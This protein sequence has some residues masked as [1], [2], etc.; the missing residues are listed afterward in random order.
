[1]R[2]IKITV[3]GAGYEMVQTRF[4]NEEMEK[5]DDWVE[6]NE[7]DYENAFLY[8]LEEIFEERSAWYECD[9]LGHYYGASLGGKIYLEDNE[10][11][12]ELE[13]SDV[14]HDM[15][16]INYTPTNE[17]GTTICCVSWEKGTILNGE[18][19]IGDDEKFDE[20]KLVLHVKEIMSPTSIYEIVTGFSYNGKEIMDE[21]PGDTTGKGFEVEID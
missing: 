2:T 17:T 12:W 8:E 15:E 4:S 18:F 19:E 21:G 13:I 6:K 1:M 20:N 11:E 14:E 5:L 16:E 10:E 9:D 3:G 7:S